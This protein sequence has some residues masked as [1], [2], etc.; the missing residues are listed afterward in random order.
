MNEKYGKFMYDDV[1]LKRDFLFRN[2]KVN[3]KKC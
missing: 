1:K 3:G 2:K